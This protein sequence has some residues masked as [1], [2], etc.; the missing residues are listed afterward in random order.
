MVAGRS[1]GEENENQGAAVWFVC[2]SRGGRRWGYGVEAK[3]FQ[4]GVAAA[5]LFCQV[6]RSRME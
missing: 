5:I 4:D 2:F 1:V 6:G 3:K